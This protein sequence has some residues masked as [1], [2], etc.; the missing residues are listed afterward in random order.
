MEIRKNK[1]TSLLT[2]LMASILIKKVL[3]GFDMGML[4]SAQTF[5][6]HFKL[7]SSQCSRTEN[8]IQAMGKVSYANT[9]G[10]LIYVIVCAQ[11]DLAYA[12]SIVI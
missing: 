6:A 1:R 4:T 5:I 12:G 11:L 10:C 3:N 9:V 2:Y 7:H 8:E